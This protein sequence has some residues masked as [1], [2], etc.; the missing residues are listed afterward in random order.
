MKVRDYMTGNPRTLPAD[1]TLGDAVE[2]MSGYS[3]RHLP[4]M[5]EGSVLGMISDRDIKMALG[6][7]AAGLDADAL[8]P[9]QADGP[10]DWFMSTGL[11]SIEA[12]ADIAVACEVF[13][14]SKFGA[15]PVVEGGELVGILSVLDIV[16]AALPLL[17]AGG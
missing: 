14:E 5:D 9:R 7:D 4:V 13:L 6:P 11:V 3:I 16:R 17:K 2:L 8:D 10:V 1:A 12:D 15:L